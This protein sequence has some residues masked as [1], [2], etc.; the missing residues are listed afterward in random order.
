MDF[1]KC[2]D[3]LIHDPPYKWA[4]LAMKFSL[5]RGNFL[6][7]F[8]LFGRI[9]GCPLGFPSKSRRSSSKCWPLSSDYSPRFDSMEVLFT[10]G[11]VSFLFSNS[12]VIWLNIALRLQTQRDVQRHSSWYFPMNV[13][14]PLSCRILLLKLTS[15]TCTIWRRSTMV[16]VDTLQE[17]I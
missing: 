1:H 12:L 6:K 14:S 9:S 8:E 17:L 2:F 10:T 13:L 15:P 11:L 7:Y 16:P 5:W 4:N 3:H